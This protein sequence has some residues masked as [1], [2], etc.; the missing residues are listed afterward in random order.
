M[1]SGRRQELTLPSGAGVPGPWLDAV[2]APQ[3]NAV[4]ISI[5]ASGPVQYQFVEGQTPPVVIAGTYSHDPAVVPPQTI[6]VFSGTRLQV[7]N[8]NIVAGNS[9]RF[10]FTH[11][12]VEM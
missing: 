10:V 4:F 9:T 1:V 5:A 11:R 12:R 8:P 2:Q 7:R 3:N 6:Q